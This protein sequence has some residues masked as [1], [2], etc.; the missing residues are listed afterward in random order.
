MFVNKPTK[1]IL[2]QCK[3]KVVIVNR[4][5]NYTEYA[6]SMNSIK[7]FFDGSEAEANALK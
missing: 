3:M 7:N 6:E 2:K 1:H 4:N 5:I